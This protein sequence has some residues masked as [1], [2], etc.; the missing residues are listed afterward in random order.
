MAKKRKSN[1]QNKNLPKKKKKRT[2]RLSRVRKDVD[3]ALKDLHFSGFGVKAGGGLMVRQRKSALSDCTHEYACCLVN[4]F[5]GPLACVP[6]FPVLQTR[7]VRYFARGNFSTGVSGIGWIACDPNYGVT[8]DFAMTFFTLPAYTLNVV[9][10]A[11]TNVGFSS[12]NSDYVHTVFGASG[13]GAE[14]RVVSCG[15]RIRYTSTELNRGGQIFA[16]TEP[17]HN[18]VQNFSQGD[19]NGYTETKWFPVTD[20]DWVTIVWYPILSYEFDFSNTFILFNPVGG[21]Y[22]AQA[23]FPMVFYITA[24]GTPITFDYECFAVYELNGLHIQGK[25]VS[26]A[27]ASGFASVHS[28]IASDRILDPYNANAMSVERKAVRK[29]QDQLL[30]T[31]SGPHLIRS[32]L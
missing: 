10:F 28:A 9:N 7:K 8:S 14:W 4:P 21:A 18:S 11:D 2:K 3:V 13:T 27:D 23:S 5:T 29:T 19:I 26:H 20:R 22:L 12:S 32:E 24:P 16:L 25:T 30:T 6:N 1:L 17:S 15:L 31:Q